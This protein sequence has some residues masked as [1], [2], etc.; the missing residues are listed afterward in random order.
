M[1]DDL[2]DLILQAAGAAPVNIG[3]LGGGC[4]GEVYRARLEGGRDVVVKLARAKGGGPP[5]IEG[6][7]LR[8][9]A[10]P[11][12]LPVPGVIHASPGIVVMD[13]IENDGGAIGPDAQRHGAELLA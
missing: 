9:L 13:Y 2:R 8:Y 7:M 6:A 10:V 11:A 12:R 3:G 4:V 5:A 1:T